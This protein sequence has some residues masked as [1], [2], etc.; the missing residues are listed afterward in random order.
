M[1]QSD[2]SFWLM[3]RAGRSRLAPR[4][5]WKSADMHL[6]GIFSFPWEARMGLTA[7]AEHVQAEQ[8]L[9]ASGLATI[10]GGIT[11]LRIEGVSNR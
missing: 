2:D 6:T 10:S 5:Q 11:L 3:K 1:P 8:I 7:A 9:G 4:L